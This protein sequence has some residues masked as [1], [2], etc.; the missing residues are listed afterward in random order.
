M[1][2]YVGRVQH[3]SNVPWRNNQNVCPKDADVATDGTLIE[4]VE[5]LLHLPIAMLATLSPIAISDALPK[6]DIAK[7]CRFESESVSTFDRCSRDET[8]ALQKLQV[9]WPQF[10]GAD[11]SACFTEATI[12]GFASY[13]ELQICLE[14]ARDVRNDESGS[15]SAGVEPTRSAPPE[16]SVADKHE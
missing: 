1:A 9:E 12:G 7:E 14:M 6:F 2:R 5:M 8:D 4:E 13:V 16:T 11:R 3:L 15:R 10:V